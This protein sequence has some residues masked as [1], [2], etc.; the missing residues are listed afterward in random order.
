M[1][2]NYELFIDSALWDTLNIKKYR[3][4]KMV[5]I[6]IFVVL[7]ICRIFATTFIAKGQAYILIWILTIR[8][9]LAKFFSHRQT[10]QTTR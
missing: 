2:Q 8:E 10:T 1:Q 4:I 3:L 6:N 5:I 7:E 9:I